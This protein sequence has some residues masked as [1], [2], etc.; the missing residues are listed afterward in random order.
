MLSQATGIFGT[1]VF[2][3]A[4]ENTFSVPVN[5]CSSILAGVVASAILAMTLDAPWPSA[6]QLGGAGLVMLAI[7]A[8]TAGPIISKRRSASAS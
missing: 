1:L 5:R 4:S 7:V 2:L 6:Y 8:L 3:D